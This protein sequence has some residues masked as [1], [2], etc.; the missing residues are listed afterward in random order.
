MVLKHSLW[1]DFF[2]CTQIQFMLFIA[3]PLW[4]SNCDGRLCGNWEKQSLFGEKKILSL[5]KDLIT[6]AERKTKIRCVCP[7]AGLFPCVCS[8]KHILAVSSTLALLTLSEDA[9]WTGDRQP[10][11][12]FGFHWLVISYPL[13]VPLCSAHPVCVKLHVC[14]L[15]PWDTSFLGYFKLKNI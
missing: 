9:E 11:G 8:S 2:M 5:I 15:S 7:L 10:V 14:S 3:W 4:Q 12:S 13:V 6:K 1:S